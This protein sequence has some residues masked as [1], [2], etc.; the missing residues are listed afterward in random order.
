MCLVEVT[1][2]ISAGRPLRYLDSRLSV[3]AV[4]CSNFWLWQACGFYE[5][6][7]G[8]AA[9]RS[10][11]LQVQASCQLD[12][13]INCVALLFTQ[14]LSYRILT[15][16]RRS[17]SSCRAPNSRQYVTATARR[18]R[19]ESD[20]EKE[21]LPGDRLAKRSRLEF[22]QLQSSPS[23]NSLDSGSL[24]VSGSFDG[25][26]DDCEVNS[27]QAPAN[28]SIIHRLFGRHWEE[29]PAKYKL[30][31]ATSMAF[32]L[33]NMVNL[34]S[35]FTCFLQCSVANY[36]TNVVLLHVVCIQSVL[37]P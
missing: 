8:S 36:L 2:Y 9:W 7:R 3:F 21:F 37:F 22:E 5:L 6:R 17:N 26:E 28:Q 11:Q 14:H 35:K 34:L 19:F 33:C 13:A 1:Q 20:R 25:S 30:V 23:S 10:P 15:G 12:F 24:D 31:F 29:L 16:Q 32:V 4:N 18:G 27:G